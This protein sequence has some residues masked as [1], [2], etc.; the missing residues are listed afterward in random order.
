VPP[1]AKTRRARRPPRTRVIRRWLALGAIV[2]VALL[3]YRPLRTYLHTRQALSERSEQVRS[4][5]GEKARLERRL[6][7][8]ATDDAL[9]REARKLGLV[10]PGERLFIVKGIDAWRR[11]GPTIKG[12]GR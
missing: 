9:T 11:R 1:R 10:E 5:R 12:D 2:L 7:A 8:A 3:Y 6:S 4:L